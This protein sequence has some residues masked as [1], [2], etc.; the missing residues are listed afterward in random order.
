MRDTPFA[1]RERTL[2]E[3]QSNSVKSTSVVVVNTGA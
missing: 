2:Q 3:N 1:V